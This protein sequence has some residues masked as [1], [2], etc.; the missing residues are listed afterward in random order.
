MYTLLL[1][2]LLCTNFVCWVYTSRGTGCHAVPTT[3]CSRRNVRRT[4]LTELTLRVFLVVFPVI[5]Y[6]TPGY[7]PGTWYVPQ[8]KF[9]K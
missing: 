7:T 4:R 1:V 9:W 2:L 6:R 5:R 3:A 8:A